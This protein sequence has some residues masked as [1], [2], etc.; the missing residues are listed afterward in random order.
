MMSL[1]VI[2]IALNIV[3]LHL[4]AAEM[5]CEVQKKVDGK[6]IRWDMAQDDEYCQC[7]SDG[8]QGDSC[9]EGGEPDK[10]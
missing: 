6:W 10:K 2:I 8:E 3:V 4:N 1:L 5:F 7:W 9:F